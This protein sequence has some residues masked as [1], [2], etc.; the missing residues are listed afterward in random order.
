[1]F[2]EIQA[3]TFKTVHIYNYLY[4]YILNYHHFSQPNFSIHQ[5]NLQI[6]R[7]AIICKKQQHI[8][9]FHPNNVISVFFSI[10]RFFSLIANNK[11]QFNGEKPIEKKLEA[12][13]FFKFEAKIYFHETW[14]CHQESSSS[15]KSSKKKNYY[16]VL[17]YVFKQKVCFIFLTFMFNFII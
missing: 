14:C 4:N 17:F 5:K 3:L 15:I 9:H 1:M 12:V 13:T 10:C 6:C 7:H 16:V 2:T 11:S 8:F